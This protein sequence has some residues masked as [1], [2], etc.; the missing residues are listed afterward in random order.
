MNAYSVGSI[1]ENYGF[2]FIWT[3]RA[4]SQINCALRWTYCSNEFQ[5]GKEHNYLHSENGRALKD[6]CHFDLPKAIK[7]G[8]KFHRNLLGYLRIV[9]VENQRHIRMLFGAA[10]KKEMYLVKTKNSKRERKEKD[11]CQL[12]IQSG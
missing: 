9:K 11:A 4:G 6:I 10:H 8:K 5:A 2:F 7:G 1:K 12:M 3:G